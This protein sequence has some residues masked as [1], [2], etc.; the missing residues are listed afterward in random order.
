MGTILKDAE[1]AFGHLILDYHLNGEGKEIVEREDG[2]IDVS[3]GPSSYFLEYSRWPAIEKEAIDLASGRVLDVGTGAGRV[4]IHLQSMGLECTGIDNSPLAVKVARERGVRSALTIPVEDISPE[5]GSFDTV[6]MFGNNFGLMGNP[7]RAMRLLGILGKMTSEDSA[8]LAE[9]LDP[10]QTDLTDHLEYQ[11]ANRAKGKLP[12]QLT[13]RV[14]HR[15]FLTPWFEYLIVSK[16]E[17]KALLKGSGWHISKFIEGKGPL[18][19]AILK[20]DLTLE[21]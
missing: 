4:C 2:Y 20:K 11:N 17:M 5:L 10:L 19:I 13:I 8:I 1:D 7:D 12:G 9:S 3:S 15:K 14:R 16:R 21:R 6:V 18:Y